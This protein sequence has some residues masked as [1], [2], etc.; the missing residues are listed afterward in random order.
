MPDY[1]TLDVKEM[2]NS[3]KNLMETIGKKLSDDLTQKLADL[4]L[5][6]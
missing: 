1:E 5:Q 4:I 6:L 3:R 2:F